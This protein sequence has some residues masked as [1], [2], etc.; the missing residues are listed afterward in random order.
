MNAEVIALVYEH[1]GTTSLAASVKVNG[2]KP[3]SKKTDAGLFLNLRHL[4]DK[5]KVQ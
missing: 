2:T 1:G 5:T 3:V 4:L